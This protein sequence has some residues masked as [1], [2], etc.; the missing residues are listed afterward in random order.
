MHF[1]AKVVET[2]MENNTQTLK[3]CS[4]KSEHFD[5]IERNEG[6]ASLYFFSTDFPS[7]ENRGLNT[8]LHNVRSFFLLR[9]TVIYRR[10]VCSLISRVK[11][12]EW[13]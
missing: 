2:T 4:S 1:I 3:I 6:D 8:A 10:F 5:A 13:C 11:M 9:L 7:T 12:C